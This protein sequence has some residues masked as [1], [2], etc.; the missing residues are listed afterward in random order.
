MLHYLWSNQCLLNQMHRTLIFQNPTRPTFVTTSNNTKNWVPN[1]WSTPKLFRISLTLKSSGISRLSNRKSDKACFSVWHKRFWHRIVWAISFLN[2]HRS[3]TTASSM[4]NT[5]D[6]S[7][8]GCP[9]MVRLGKQCSWSIKKKSTFAPSLILTKPANSTILPSSK[10]R[11]SHRSL[12]STTA[13]TKCWLSW[14][15]SPLI[16]SKK[17]YK[18]KNEKN[19]VNSC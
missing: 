4:I 9:L 2:Q 14:W 8:E 5:E 19:K 16:K 12:T 18:I 13:R 3:A 17:I 15:W 6:H 1:T 11:V 10:P 7:L